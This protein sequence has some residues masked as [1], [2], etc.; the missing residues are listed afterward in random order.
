MKKEHIKLSPEDREQLLGM[1]AKSSLT[2]RTYK[3]VS[4]L[5]ALDEGQTYVEVETQVRLSVV[6]LGKLATKYKQVGLECLHDAPRS[7]RPIKIDAKQRDQVTL[8]AC[9]ETPDGHGHWSIRLLADKMVEL[10]YCEEIS[11]SSVHDILKKRNSS[12]T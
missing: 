12:H 6:S 11:S 10:G 9:E 2:A 4:A 5:L 3:R 1:L 7:G 8:L